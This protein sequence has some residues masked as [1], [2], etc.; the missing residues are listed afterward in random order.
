MNAKKTQPGA[1]REAAEEVA[2]APNLKPPDSPKLGTK[3]LQNGNE[4]ILLYST[5]S[6]SG[7]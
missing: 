4:I 6:N 7:L 1:G 3:A 5:I 2:E